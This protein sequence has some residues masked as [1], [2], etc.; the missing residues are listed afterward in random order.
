MKRQARV[1]RETGETSITVQLD[2]DG[3]G[4]F[5][6][7]SQVGFLDHMLALLARHGALDLRVEARGDLRVDAHHTVEDT[8]ITLGRAV[9]EALGQKEG[10]SRY[11]WAALPMDE[12]LAL[13]AVDL[14]G[15]GGLFYD[16][17][18]PPGR[19]GDLDGELVEEFLRALAVN[20][21][22][23]LHVRLLCGRNAH[24]S[25]EAVFKGLGRALRQAVSPDPR[26]SGVPSTKGTLV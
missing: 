13:V 10:I 24:H 26:L 14:S 9:A 5:G 7:T 4:E 3:R 12:A 16:V 19:L 15:R 20:A 23:T 6:G 2:L 8:G 11:G 17:S 21:G 22:L 18:L 1:S 25:V